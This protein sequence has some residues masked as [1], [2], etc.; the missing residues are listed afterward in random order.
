MDGAPDETSLTL[1]VN[2]LELAE[3]SEIDLQDDKQNSEVPVSFQH[4]KF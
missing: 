1:S 3:A 4:I 2:P